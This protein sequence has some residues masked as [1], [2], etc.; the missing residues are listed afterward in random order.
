MQ[1]QGYKPRDS[2]RLLFKSAARFLIEDCGRRWGK[3]LTGINWLLEG[4]F[5]DGGENFWISPIFAQARSVY[6]R[7]MKAQKDYIGTIIKHYS[8]SELRIEYINDAAMMF[9]SGD[10][11]ENLRGWGMK[12]VV[13]DECARQNRMLWTEVIRPSVSDT[14]GRVLFI[15]TPRGKNWFYELYNKGKD[16]LLPEYE[17]WKYPT[18]DNPKISKEDISEAKRNLPQDVFKQ[19]YLAEFLDDCSGVFRNVLACIKQKHVE[20]VPYDPGKVYYAGLDLARLTDFTVLNILDEKGDQVFFDRFNLL[21]WVV[22]KR[23]IIEACK[24]YNAYVLMEWNGIGDP[25]FEDL[26]RAGLN[27]SA[28]KIT[29]ELKKKIIECLMLS[30]EQTRLSLLDIPEQYNELDVFEYQMSKAGNIIYG[31]PEG[32]HD[33]CVTSLALSNWRLYNRQQVGMMFSQ[34]DVF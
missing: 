3:T 32:Y 34:H 5:N 16:K 33:D 14:N 25:I 18:S 4:T 20:N 15:S 12:R 29:G 27:V 31:A 6:R 30:L 11:Y 17:A 28:E 10:N 19:E 1:I 7:L 9:R 22:Q 2:Q 21:D 13:I 8:D 24:R 23:R 26:R